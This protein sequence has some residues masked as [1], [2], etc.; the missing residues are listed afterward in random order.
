MFA[1]NGDGTWTVRFIVGGAQTFVTVNRMLPV[2]G[3]DGSR[4]GLVKPGA[5]WASGWGLDANGDHRLSDD[6]GNEL[7][8]ALAEKAYA[9][10]NESGKIGQDGTNRY[11]GIDGGWVSDAMKH[12]SG[13]T[14]ST[15]TLS[16]MNSPLSQTAL[17]NAVSAGQAVGIDSKSDP[18]SSLIIENHAYIVTGYNPTT[19]RFQLF[20]PW[21]FPDNDATGRVAQSP[22]V[23]ASWITL[24]DNFRSVAAVT[25]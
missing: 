4:G 21:G 8:V 25:L 3:D 5:P 20:N 2:I 23:E 13:R 7:W 24:L 19:Q 16:V 14:A 11:I 18:G 15:F 17:I 1:D 10:L 9:Q 22:I 6:P 12:I